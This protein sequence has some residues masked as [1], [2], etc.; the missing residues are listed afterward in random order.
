MLSAACRMGFP[1]HAPAG[2]L[3][4]GT[5]LRHPTRWS[6]STAGP[7]LATPTG[8]RELPLQTVPVFRITGT[9]FRARTA[10]GRATRRRHGLD[11]ARA[12]P[13]HKMLWW[14]ARSPRRRP[15]CGGGSASC[16]QTLIPAGPLLP[17]DLLPETPAPG[18]ATSNPPARLAVRRPGRPAPSTGRAQPPAPGPPAA[19]PA[20]ARP[21]AD[22]RL[23]P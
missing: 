15:A 3:R 1:C 17:D 7:G 8:E 5:E 23:G 12:G 20:G 21:P 13:G 22:T 19:P 2:E 6:W 18:K 11:P 14:P 16:P 9:F 10:A 4:H